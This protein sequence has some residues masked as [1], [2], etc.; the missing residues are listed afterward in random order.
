MKVFLVA[1]IILNTLMP[2]RSFCRQQTDSLLSVLE[3]TEEDSVKARLYFELGNLLSDPYPDSAFMYYTKS[4]KITEQYAIMEKG[5]REEMFERRTARVLVRIG[6]IHNEKGYFAN[7]MSLFKRALKI[8]EKLGYKKGIL[9]CYIDIGLVH[10]SQENRSKAVSYI[11]KALSL[12]REIKD[13]KAELYCLGNLGVMYLGEEKFKEA[14]TYLDRTL[15]MSKEENDIFGIANTLQNLGYAYF[16]LK[17]YS[18]AEDYYEQSLE[19]VKQINDKNLI[20]RNYINFSSL[21]KETGRYDKAVEFAHKGLVLGRETGSIILEQNAYEVLSGIYETKDLKDSALVYLKMFMEAKDSIF[22]IEK[23]KK[24]SEIEA[25]YENENKQLQIELLEKENE[26]HVVSKGE[27]GR[28]LIYLLSGLI[29]IL[30]FAIFLF[31][32]YMQ[33]NKAYRNLVRKNLEVVDSEIKLQESADIET[34][35]ENDKEADNNLSDSHNGK[36]AKSALTEKQKEKIEKTINYAMEKEK[37]FLKN[38]VTINK[39]AECMDISRSYVSQV[40]NERYNQNFSNFIN[41]YRIREA[42]RL[43]SFE[44][45]YNYTIESIASMVGFNSK[46]AFNNAFKKFTGVTP[47]FFLR[48]TK[49]KTSKQ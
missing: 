11:K 6:L 7:A 36:Y 25:K 18:Q 8:N 4:L 27:Q 30:I 24:I 47:S 5:E 3:C 2:F 28:L 45:S 32:Q 12:S 33:K 9:S 43:L 14:I 20:A 38:D 37:V 42:L 34:D 35:K 41:E 40:I 48:N 39:L 46:S 29:I 16:K 1:I 22:N 13:K 23:T 31:V 15:S 19:A 26:L 44:E 10:L 21:Y 17:D 49:D